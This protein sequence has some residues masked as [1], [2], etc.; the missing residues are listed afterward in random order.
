M[1]R[2]QLALAVTAVSVVSSAEVEVGTDG[3]LQ[4]A[5]SKPKLD[6][7]VD[8]LYR[9]ADDDDRC[10]LQAKEGDAMELAFNIT[11][12][13]KPEVIIDNDKNS[14]LLR[15]T[16]GQRISGIV[17]VALGR[18]GSVGSMCVGEVRRATLKADIGMKSD[19]SGPII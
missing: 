1:V 15:A 11:L 2:W 3:S 7:G 10:Q 5:S 19:G 6:A 16:V 9:P 4:A 18:M 13:G 17:P 8:V 14:G 12:P